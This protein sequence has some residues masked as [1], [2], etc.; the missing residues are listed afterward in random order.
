MRAISRFAPLKVALALAILAP[1]IFTPAIFAPVIFA[2]VPLTLSALAAAKDKGEKAGTEERMGR[3]VEANILA[4]HAYQVLLARKSGKGDSSCYDAG[5]VSDEALE[6]LVNHQANLLATS[7]SDMKAWAKGT[8]HEFDPSQ[9]LDA[10]QATALKISASAPVNVFTE[11]LAQMVRVPRSQIR[12]LANL[13]QTILEVERDG[14]LLQSEFDLYIDLGLPVY[15][16]QMGLPGDDGAFLEAGKKLAAQT[17]P[18]PFVTDAAAWQIAGRKIWNWGEKKLHIRDEQVLARE[19]LAE[20]DVKP[21]IP[22]MRML[23]PQRIAIIGHSFTIGEHWSSP[24]SFVAIVTAMMF[25]ENRTV[26][27]K[28]FKAGGLTSSRALKNF[29]GEALAWKPDKVLF[30]V[31]NRDDADFEALRKM[32]KGF[33][34][35]GAE[36]YIFDNLRDPEEDRRDT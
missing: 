8:A 35:S 12:A 32:S 22:R 29:Y 13:Y 15:I 30:V 18:S 31:A 7:P 33:A 20:Q 14:D 5:G 3:I 21:L 11:Y 4:T 19:L 28:Q 16:G 23:K 36:T 6:S 17:C 34:D 26:E 10:M 24:S 2:P 1:V 25:K 27:F 9:D